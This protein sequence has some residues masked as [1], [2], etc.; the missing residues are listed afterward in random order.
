M[1]KEYKYSSRAQLAV[2]KKELF[3]LE[4]RRAKRSS[5]GTRERKRLKAKRLQAFGE[6]LSI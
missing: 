2:M 3:L 1:K 5:V 4:R 6:A